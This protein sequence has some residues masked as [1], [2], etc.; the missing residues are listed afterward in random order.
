[1]TYRGG[2]LGRVRRTLGAVAIAAILA[3]GTGSAVAATA[4]G[5]LITGVLCM[6]YGSVNPGVQYSASYCVTGVALVANPQILA[7][8]IATPSIESSGATLTYCIWVSN[9]SAFTSAFNVHVIDIIPGSSGVMAYVQGQENW[10][11]ATPGATVTFGYGSQPP[12]N[13]FRT[14][15]WGSECPAGQTGPYGIR[16]VVSLIGP[17][18]SALLCWK[19]SIL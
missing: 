14:L 9:V 11:T 5:T 15:Y 16:W 19:A 6:T 7:T 10:I 2:R 1:M 18:K 3:G 12:W 17:G 4:E 13:A 8:K